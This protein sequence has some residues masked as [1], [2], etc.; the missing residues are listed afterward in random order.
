MDS[1]HLTLQWT[2]LPFLVQVWDSCR[3][4]RVILSFLIW[5]SGYS[6][7]SVFG[8][9]LVCSVVINEWV[10]LFCLPMD[11][12]SLS[13]CHCIIIVS[14]P[15]DSL[16]DLLSSVK[17]Y[18]SY[19][20]GCH[21]WLQ[22]LGCFHLLSLMNGYCSFSSQWLSPVMVGSGVFPFVVSLLWFHQQY[23]AFLFH[24]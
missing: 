20:S 15:D 24:G 4:L 7:P 6:R 12:K 19:S 1:N 3:M 9:S 18:F 5:M 14:I 23:C 13:V 2:H 22:A 21:I 10:L 17:G 16:W 8:L 11:L